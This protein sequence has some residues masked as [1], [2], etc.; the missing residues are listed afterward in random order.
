MRLAFQLIAISYHYHYS[1]SRVE[2]TSGKAMP[3]TDLQVTGANSIQ[4]PR[5]LHHHCQ[6]QPRHPPGMGHWLQG[7]CSG[8][9]VSVTHT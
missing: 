9:S 6:H 7:S 1:F 8:K 4:A 2:V 5:E 3:G